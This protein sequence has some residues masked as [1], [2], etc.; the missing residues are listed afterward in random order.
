M[1]TPRGS[2]ISPI[3]MLIFIIV[4]TPQ[5]LRA[6]EGISGPNTINEDIIRGIELL[7]NWEFDEAE[8]LFYKIIAE[9]P[10]DPVGHF[11]LAMTTWSHLASGFWSPETVKQYGER[12]DK[13]ISVA[14]E[15]IENGKADSFTY[16]YLGGAVGFKG[17]FQLMQRKF[18]SSFL[19][20]LD[21]IDALKTCLR[22]DP[23]N[24]DALFGLGAFDYYTARLSGVLKFLSY[25][26][27]HKGDKEEGIRKLH[28]AT[29]QAIYS[30]IEA[31]SLLI[32]IYLFTERDHHKALPFAIELAERFK[33]NPRYKFLL[34][35]TYIMLG[36]D[37]MYRS[38]LNWFYR[39]SHRDTS[40]TKSAMWGRRALYLEAIYLLFHDQYHKARSKLEAVLSQADSE[41]DPAMIAWPLL[42]KGMSYDFEGKR[43]KALEHYRGILKMEN[44]AGAQF[45]A[46]KYID[47]P[48]KKRAPFIGY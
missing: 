20:A 32:H 12:I 25:L 47:T 21:A 7:Y 19:L 18:L 5:I 38:V 22:I 33:K 13:A 6:S 27:L 48:P 46:L 35:V 26:F 31:K 3:H 29:E 43:E 28:V 11:Y 34:G 8:T 45:L 9:K 40:I 30:T 42:K 10:E 41:S 24:K 23:D 37:D 2:K 39:Q 16:F 4:L 14:R 36:R 44:G 17:R 1:N 15:G